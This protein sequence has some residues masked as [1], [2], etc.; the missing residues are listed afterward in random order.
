VTQ[1]PELILL[2]CD[3]NQLTTLDVTYQTGLKVLA[4]KGNQLT[5]LDLTQNTL[6]GHEVPLDIIYDNKY[7][8]CYLSV[9]NN[10]G[11]GKVCVWTESFPPAGFMLCTDGSPNV[12][13][14]TDCSK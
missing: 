6:L 4:C 8:Y 11:L 9:G 10:P 13:F 3:D 1:N 12:T 7:Y 14:T 5:R 2:D